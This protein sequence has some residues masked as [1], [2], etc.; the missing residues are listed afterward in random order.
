MKSPLMLCLALMAG[1]AA[2]Q[3]AKPHGGFS[4]GIEMREQATS[5]DLGLPIYPGAQVQ[6]DTKD[7]KGAVTLG[8][9]GGLFG[10]H[11][12]VAQYRSSDSLDEVA[13]FYRRALAP[14]GK[15]L[16]CRADNSGKLA[17]QP[18]PGQLGCE[19]AEPGRDGLVLKVG[20][21]KDQRVVAFQ[22]KGKELHFQL[23]RLTA[24]GD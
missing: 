12:A 15:A 8:L 6:R 2:A 21:K 4:A 23:V 13:G 20:S 17:P 22:I 3:E 14:Y 11:L 1:T 7:D 9:W 24:R 18:A 16:E 5:K 10:V 19:D